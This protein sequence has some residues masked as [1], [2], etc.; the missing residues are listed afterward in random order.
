MKNL[1][2]LKEDKQYIISSLCVVEM[3]IFMSVYSRFLMQRWNAAVFS[4]QITDLL[5]CWI[6]YVIHMPSFTSHHPRS[7]L[8]WFV[9]FFWIGTLMLT[10]PC[11][12]Y[13]SLWQ[14]WIQC[15]IVSLRKG[16]RWPCLSRWWFNCLWILGFS[17]CTISFEATDSQNSEP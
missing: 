4:A 11:I 9:P 1:F 17:L 6:Q 3:W 10:K 2:T 13:L 14:S 8:N 16:T 12:H 5:V 15:F 7:A